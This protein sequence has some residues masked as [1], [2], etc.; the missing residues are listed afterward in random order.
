MNPIQII[1]KFEEY[2]V[3]KEYPKKNPLGLINNPAYPSPYFNMSALHEEAI[4]YLLSQDELFQKRVSIH[5]RCFRRNDMGLIGYSPYHLSFFEMCAFAWLG[6]FHLLQSPEIDMELIKNMATFLK[7]ILGIDRKKLIVTIFGGGTIEGK[8]FEPDSHV[9]K[10]WVDEGVA[11]KKRNSKTNFII[12]DEE[13]RGCGPSQEIFFDRG[14]DVVLGRYVEIASINKYIFLSPFK[15]F[16]KTKNSAIGCG[17]GIERISMILENKETVF[18]ISEMSPLLEL[19]KGKISR[20]TYL[21]YSP[22]IYSLMDL[23]RAFIFMI[24]D[25]QLWDNSSRG[26]VLRRM[27]KNIKGEIEF[28]GL[29][30]LDTIELIN[31]IIDVYSFRYQSLSE[32]RNAILDIIFKN[33]ELI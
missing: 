20:D 10:I 21:L 22:Y 11:V 32:S 19:L 31:K 2:F 29:N 5:E 16:K 4:P 9:E 30:K 15:S 12:S 18:D 23:T 28:L 3:N 26:K 17:F 24:Y 6:P 7:D 25:G 14:A 27:L 13:R 1:K 8:N 33:W